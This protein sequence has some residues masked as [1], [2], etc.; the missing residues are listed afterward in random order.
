MSDEEHVVGGGDAE[1]TGGGGPVGGA[2]GGGD[3][4]KDARMWG[5]LAHLS[6]LSACLCLPVVGPLIIWLIKKDEF[7]FVDDQG[8]ESVN[9]Q[10][11]MLIAVVVVIILGWI[12]VIGLVTMILGPAVGIFNLV[13]II[14]ATIQANNGVNYRYPVNLRLIK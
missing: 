8:K 13:F 5:M 11:T 6:A 12:P 1:E 2:P 10:I 9:F 14:L 7:S 4:D 3:A